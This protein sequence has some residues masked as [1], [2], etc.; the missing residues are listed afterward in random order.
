MFVVYDE[1]CN[2]SKSF[3]DKKEAMKHVLNVQGELY[4]DGKFLLSYGL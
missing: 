1:M 4:E 2:E 3:E